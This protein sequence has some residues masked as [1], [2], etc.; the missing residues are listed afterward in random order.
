MMYKKRYNASIHAKSSTR[1]SPPYEGGDEEVVG[2]AFQ[3]P[4]NPLL[5]EGE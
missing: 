5:H 4:P 3:P 1:F 2:F